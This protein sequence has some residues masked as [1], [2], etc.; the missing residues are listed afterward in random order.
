MFSSISR[1]VCHVHTQMQLSNSSICF[2]CKFHLVQF[3]LLN[4]NF[5]VAVVEEFKTEVRVRTG[6]GILFFSEALQSHLPSNDMYTAD[7]KSFRNTNRL[8]LQQINR[9]I[10]KC[11]HCNIFPMIKLC[12][13]GALMKIIRRVGSLF[14]KG[15]GACVNWFQCSTTRLHFYNILIIGE[16]VIIIGTDTDFLFCSLAVPRR[17]LESL[18]R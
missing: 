9:C 7:A 18:H 3:F 8:V 11:M 14:P 10:G 1:F 15:R 5:S 17:F 16:M 2:V 13:I 12:I 6:Y 4:C